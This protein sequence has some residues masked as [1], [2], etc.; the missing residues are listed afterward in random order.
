MF[1]SGSFPVTE[2]AVPMCAWLQFLVQSSFSPA[3]YPKLYTHSGFNATSCTQSSWL[4]YANIVLKYG[5]IWVNVHNRYK[6]ECFEIIN[7]KEGDKKFTLIL[8]KFCCGYCAPKK[9]L[10][11]QSCTQNLCTQTGYNL[12]FAKQNINR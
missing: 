12:S 6:T 7:L 3:S 8:D 9:L 4:K 11:V 10:S 5:H 1:L 2:N